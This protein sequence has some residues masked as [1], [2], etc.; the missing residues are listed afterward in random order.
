MRAVERSGGRLTMKH[1]KALLSRAVRGGLVLPWFVS[2]LAIVGLTVAGQYWPAALVAVAA[3]A[4]TVFQ[5]RR[6]QGRPVVT[7]EA[8]RKISR[9]RA[10]QPAEVDR[11]RPL[12]ALVVRGTR[13]GRYVNV[14]RTP[15]DSTWVFQL[16][17]TGWAVAPSTAEGLVESDSEHELRSSLRYLPQGPLAD[18]IWRRNFDSLRRGRRYRGLPLR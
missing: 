14:V 15:D 16:G 11:H 4:G 7:W 13:R 2:V 6:T 10:P 8:A 9:P 5:L 12:V 1:M 3:G 17:P 18:E